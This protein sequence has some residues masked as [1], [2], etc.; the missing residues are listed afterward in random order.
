MYLSDIIKPLITE[1]LREMCVGKK[2]LFYDEYSSDET[3]IECKDVYFASDDGD[4]WMRFIDKDGKRYIPS[5]QGIDI[6]FEIK[7]E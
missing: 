7:D 3:L 2:V 5:G 1:K 4:C 6:Y